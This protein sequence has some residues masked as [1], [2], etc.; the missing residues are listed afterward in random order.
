MFKNFGNFYY[1]DCKII[2]DCKNKKSYHANQLLDR[3]AN[4]T[5]RS[6]QN[7][8]TKGIFCSYPKSEKTKE[9]LFTPLFFQ[10]NFPEY[11]SY[12]FEGLFLKMK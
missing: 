7:K 1:K 5:R 4:I 10:W 8:T 9:K 11:I 3:V 6:K 2:K 12:G